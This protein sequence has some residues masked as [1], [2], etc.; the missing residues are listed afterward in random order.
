MVSKDRKTSPFWMSRSQKAALTYI[1]PLIGGLWLFILFFFKNE[2]NPL[3][4]ETGYHRRG[5]LLANSI[6]EGS[7]FADVFNTD[8]FK[9]PGYSAL[10]G[11]V[12]YVFGE[13]PLLLRALGFIPFFVLAVVV[14]NMATLIAG[15]RARIFAFL[16]ALLSPV[17]FFFSLQ[18]Y[19]DIYIACAVSIVLHAIVA[20][21]ITEKQLKSNVT[22]ALLL[23]F[24]VLYFMR[25][26]QFW[27]MLVLAVPSLL[28]IKALSFSRQKKIV[29]IVASFSLI[30]ISVI[31]FREDLMQLISQT[32]FEDTESVIT[33]TQLSALSGYSFSSAEEILS[34]LLDLKF[35]LITIV[36]KLTMFFL[37]PHP[38]ARSGAGQD[39]MTLFNGFEQNDWGGYQWI[40]VLLVYGLQWIQ[41]ISLLGFLLAGLMG[42]WS[43]NR[44]VFLVFAGFYAAY[45]IITIFSGNE[46]R[47]GL[48]IYILY[49]IIPALGYSWFGKRLRL[50]FPV[51]TLLFIGIIIV[52]WF[53][54][55]VPMIVVP[56]LIFGLLYLTRILDHKQIARISR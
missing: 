29:V 31:I 50:I 32:F 13:F 5:V 43:F 34:A 30:T 1:I 11:F 19:R 27:L 2:L 4:D 35:I 17:L 53:G 6:S 37:G 20:Y 40:D 51:L 47:W 16:T 41:N 21:A 33:T 25:T 38:F 10:A 14:A 7:F 26:P 15:E 9:Y 52:R 18:L 36:A 49:C 46:T 28:V 48:P 22:P 8:L 44:K 42:L 3:G 39:I 45:A 23:A 55:F 56:V 24:A 54:V 12:Y